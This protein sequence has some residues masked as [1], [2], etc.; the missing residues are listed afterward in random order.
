[1]TCRVFGHARITQVT[2]HNVKGHKIKGSD[3][4]RLACMEEKVGVRAESNSALCTK[5]TRKG[6]MAYEAQDMLCS[7]TKFLPYNKS[8]C[9]TTKKVAAYMV[10]GMDIYCVDTWTL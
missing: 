3:P 7:E 5:G 6:L 10:E 8:K 2:Q 1:M 4:G 9:P